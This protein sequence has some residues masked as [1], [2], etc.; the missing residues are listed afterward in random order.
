MLSSNEV[1]VIVEVWFDTNGDT[2]QVYRAPY[3]LKLDK[4]LSPVL[5][6]IE[7]RL[8]DENIIG[9]MKVEKVTP[10]TPATMTSIVKDDIVS[11]INFVRGDYICI[12]VY[13]WVMITMKG[14]ERDYPILK[15]KIGENDKF[16]NLFR[17]YEEML[18][19][20]ECFYDNSAILRVRKACLLG[21][22]KDSERKENSGTGEDDDEDSD[23]SESDDD[24]GVVSWYDTP[25]GC[26]LSGEVTLIA[27]MYRNL[28][29]KYGMG[30]LLNHE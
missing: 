11:D 28:R 3:A 27:S 9:K 30:R 12:S 24:S 8:K 5:N 1:V 15:K 10:S 26:R 20:S 23:S 6:D 17:E 14:E 29:F 18:D 16:S 22:G 4:P 7:R 13:P 21:I 2:K 19:D 25:R